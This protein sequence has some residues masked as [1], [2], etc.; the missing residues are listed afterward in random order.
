MGAVRKG[1]REGEGERKEE[2]ERK[3]KAI[4]LRAAASCTR[5]DGHTAGVKQCSLLRGRSLQV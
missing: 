3:N 4:F 1:G 2:R 5:Q